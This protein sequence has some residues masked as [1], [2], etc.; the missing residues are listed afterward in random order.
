MARMCK[1]EGIEFNSVMY[2][3]NEWVLA[4]E[5]APYIKEA[6]KTSHNTGSPKSSP[7]FVES[8][9]PCDYCQGQNDDDESTSPCKGCDRYS[10]FI[11]GGLRAG[12]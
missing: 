3:A 5:V 8:D 2:E 4:S 11:G 10:H 6:V 12:A 7:V 1:I 9:D